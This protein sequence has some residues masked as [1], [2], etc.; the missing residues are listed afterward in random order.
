MTLDSIP[1][2]IIVWVITI[3][4]SFIIDVYLTVVHCSLHRQH[5][6]GWDTPTIRTIHDVCACIYIFGALLLYMVVML[7]YF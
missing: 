5:N 7:V 4:L 1:T 2:Y 6:G 3:M